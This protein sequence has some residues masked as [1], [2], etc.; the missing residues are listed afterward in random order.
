MPMPD[1]Q[2]RFEHLGDRGD[3]RGELEIAGGSV[4][5]AGSGFLKSAHLPF[6]E[7]DAMRGDHFGREQPEVAPPLAG[8][9]RFLVE[10]EWYL[11]V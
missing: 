1:V 2:P 7:V 5:H 3:S 10:C 6:V 4:R 9:R 11:E 8:C